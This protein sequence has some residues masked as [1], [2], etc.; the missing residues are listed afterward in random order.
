MIK[1]RWGLACTPLI[2]V[3]QQPINKGNCSGEIKNIIKNIFMVDPK[4]FDRWL[5]IMNKTR[6][7]FKIYLLDDNEYWF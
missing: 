3:I 6:N 1:K 2:D 7:E 4:I 5:Y